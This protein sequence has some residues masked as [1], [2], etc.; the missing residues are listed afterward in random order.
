MNQIDE[1]V[2]FLRSVIEFVVAQSH[3]IVLHECHNLGH[4][5]RLVEG[6][7]DCPLEVVSRIQEKDILLRVPQ[8][9]CLGKS[10]IRGKGEQGRAY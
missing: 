3:G 2:Q 10:S 8:V 1:F 6:V 4:N 5:L 7:P 9:L